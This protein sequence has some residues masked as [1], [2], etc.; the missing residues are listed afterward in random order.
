MCFSGISVNLNCAFAGLSA[1]QTSQ[2]SECH[3]FHGQ[4][5]E[6]GHHYVPGPDICKLCIC[7]N[8]QPKGCKAVLCSPPQACKSFQI[9]N[10]CCEFICLDDALTGNSEKNSDFG[11]W[12]IACGVTATLSLSLLF[13]IVNRFRQRKIRVSAN[14]QTSDE[15]RNIASIG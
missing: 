11:I 4:T 15:P 3:D 10:S 6:Q 9:G 5:I 2:M 12:L 1:L 8:G 13:F 14:R 7:D